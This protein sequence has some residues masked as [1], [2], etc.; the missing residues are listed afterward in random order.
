VT[1]E[2]LRRAV[3]AVDAMGQ[4]GEG[5]RVVARA[6]AD[7]AFRARLLADATAACAELEIDAVNANAPT[8]TPPISGGWG[9]G[10]PFP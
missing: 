7:A 6:W 5:A 4:A 1:A 8:V 9:R 3:E 2:A 10:R